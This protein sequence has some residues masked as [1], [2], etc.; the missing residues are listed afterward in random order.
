MCKNKAID[1]KVLRA[2]MKAQAMSNIGVSLA[3]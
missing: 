1:F 3:D 2:E